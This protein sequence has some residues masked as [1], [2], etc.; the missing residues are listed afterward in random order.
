M[1]YSQT[2]WPMIFCGKGWRLKESWRI[3]SALSCSQIAI[4]SVYV[5]MPSGKIFNMKALS[6]RCRDQAVDLCRG[7]HV[8]H[9]ANALQNMK[10]RLVSQRISM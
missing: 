2:D 5:T 3:G 9:M 1:A 10:L 4:S 8:R 6:E 7:L